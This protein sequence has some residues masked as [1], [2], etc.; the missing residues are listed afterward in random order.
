MSERNGSSEPAVRSKANGASVL[1]SQPPAISAP[2]DADKSGDVPSGDSI[3]SRSAAPVPTLTALIVSPSLHAGAA[4]AGTLQLVRIL[5]SAGHRAVVASSGGRMVDDVVATGATFIPMNLASTN[6]AIML[7]NARA[8]RRIVREHHCDVIHAHGRAPGWSA[9][10]AARRTGVPF[11]TSWYKGFREQN[12]FKRLYNSVMVRGDRVIAAGDQIVDLIVERYRTSGDRITV[13][14]PVVDF[15]RFD[16][17]RV[18]SA[19]IDAVRNAWGLSPEIRV[20]LVVGRIVRRKGH[21]VVVDAV[22]RL[23]EMGLKDFLCVFVGEDQGRSRYTGELWDLVMTSGTGDVIRMAGPADDLPAALATAT[24]VV[25]AAIQP[26]GLQRAILEAEAMARPVVVS[27]LGAGPDSV[28]SPPAVAEDR[29]TGLRFSAGDSIALSTALLRLFSLPE[30]ERAAIGARGRAWVLANFNA[31]AAA[32][33]TL[34]LYADIATRRHSLSQ[35]QSSP[36]MP[37]T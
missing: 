34:Q 23:K 35:M 2:H 9:Y 21:H 20:V 6:P 16:P 32:E 19:R 37:L 10:L 13:I 15:D 36:A 3:M 24:V 30:P 4:D 26:E 29:M 33:P 5:T 8:M 14:P 12:L 22:R 11:L 17:A 31:Q 1:I 18:S 25:N 27:D 7:R 28:L